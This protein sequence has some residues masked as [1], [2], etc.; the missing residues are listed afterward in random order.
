[1]VCIAVHHTASSY[2]VFTLYRNLLLMGHIPSSVRNLEFGAYL[3]L[4]NAD[5]MKDVEVQRNK[6]AAPHFESS[7]LLRFYSVECA[8]KARFLV[9][10]LA[11]RHGDTSMIPA[12]TFGS[13][14]HDLDAGRK[15]L[16]APAAVPPA[17]ALQLKNSERQIHIRQAHQVW[18]Y[19][20]PCRMTA[21][22]ENWLHDVSAWLKESQ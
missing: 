17:P 1:M 12:G 4:K 2:S 21:D 10:E 5:C 22:V 7:L 6:N 3:L 16:R 11:N 14:G 19:H 13:C 20:I 15:A 18:R 8:M 9:S